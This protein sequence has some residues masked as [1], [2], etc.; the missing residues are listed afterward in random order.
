MNLLEW[1]HLKSAKSLWLETRHDG[2]N[3]LP[4][5]GLGVFPPSGRSV[6]RDWLAALGYR[7]TG[8]V[9]P[10][11]SQSRGAEPRASLSLAKPV[12]PDS[13][14][15]PVRKASCRSFCV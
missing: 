4:A 10:V 14:L 8:E 13:P 7:D 15:V 1:L 12:P 3:V 9:M 2:R 5:L 11:W 6:G